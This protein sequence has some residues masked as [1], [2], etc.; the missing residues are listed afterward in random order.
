MSLREFGRVQQGEI[1]VTQGNSEH[2]NP[3]SNSPRQLLVLG[4]VVSADDV[5]QLGQEGDQ[6]HVEGQEIS[7][8]LDDLDDHGDDVAEG[9]EYFQI[10]DCFDE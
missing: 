3:I 4:R 6:D 10:H 9:H 2:C 7:Q 8:I 1:K 5:E